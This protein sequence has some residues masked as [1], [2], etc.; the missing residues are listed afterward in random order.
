VLNYQRQ[1]L[2]IQSQLSVRRSAVAGSYPGV[3]DMTLVEA[4]ARAGSTLPRPAEAI[5][6]TSQRRLPAHACDPGNR[7]TSSAST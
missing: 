7:R 1:I 2:A 3:R 6:C 5:S 4:L